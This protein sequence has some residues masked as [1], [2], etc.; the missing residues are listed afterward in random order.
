[1]S[2][3]LALA[4]SGGGGVGAVATAKLVHKGYSRT[5]H[6][7]PLLKILEKIDLV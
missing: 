1:M 2:T 4:V 3:S 5:T 7:L 6:N